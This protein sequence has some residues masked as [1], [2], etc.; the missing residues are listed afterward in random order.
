MSNDD[1]RS[2]EERDKIRGLGPSPRKCVESFQNRGKELLGNSL[3]ATFLQCTWKGSR[4]NYK[5]RT[6]NSTNVED[7]DLQF[8]SL[9]ISSFS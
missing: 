8:L 4:K 1:M 7:G 5:F 3:N 6:R 9:T 2:R